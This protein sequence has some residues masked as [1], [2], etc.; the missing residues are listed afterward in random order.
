MTD[1]DYR[2]RRAQRRAAVLALPT[3]RLRRHA[4][5][6]APQEETSG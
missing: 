1:S 4:K 6:L 5:I 2:R 3:V